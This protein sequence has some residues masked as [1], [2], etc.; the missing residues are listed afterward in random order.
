MV[1]FLIRTERILPDSNR[2]ACG[3]KDLR[4]IFK[5]RNLWRNGMKRSEAVELLNARL[6]FIEQN[7][8]LTEKMIAVPGFDL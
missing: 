6:D 2:N 4:T 5:E 1:G 3:K 7:E 8:W